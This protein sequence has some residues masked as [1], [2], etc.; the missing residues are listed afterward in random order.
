MQVGSI[1]KL[2]SIF[3]QSFRKLGVNVTPDRLE[4]LA[5]TVYTAMTV[6]TRYFHTLE[7]VFNLS[8]PQNAIVSFTAIY[9]DIVYFQV[10][11][12]FSPHIW[13]LLSPFIRWN[14]DK[15]S[16]VD[17]IPESERMIHM[18]LDLFD[19]RPGQDI[20][21]D[22]IMNEFL[23]ALVM[24]KQLETLLSWK[25]L[26]LI[27]VCIEG[28]IPFRAVAP[29]EKSYFDQMEL[30]FQEVIKRYGLD[31]S[32]QELI[33][34]LELAVSF[35][36]RDI[37]N[38]AEA[39]PGRFLENTWKLL[40]ETNVALRSPGV[41]TVGA[42]REALQKMDHFFETLNVDTV[43]K[44]YR[45]FPS[46]E[47]YDLLM[48][49]ARYNLQVARKYMS[50]KIL[51][52]TILE[53]L[54]LATGGDAPLALFLGDSPSEGVNTKRLENYLPELKNPDWVDSGSILYELLESGRATR[55]SFEMR[56]SPLSLFVYKSIPP[57]HLPVC[58][59]RM[60]DFHSGKLSPDDFLKGLSP[61]VI[62]PVARACSFMVP[63]RQQSLLKYAGHV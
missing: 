28:T 31:L 23:S 11:N 36:N 29:G 53:A 39:D 46:A 3:Q 47:D 1:E 49:Q 55:S 7:H 41:Y 44:Q 13:H 37:E 34:G 35:A 4:T 10:D 50:I 33:N 16:V 60:A 5:V 38:F 27:T 59:Q 43:F 58:V 62:Q 30:R 52:S 45:G 18:A 54:A 57:E 2:I 6:P 15:L 20:A 61:S 51:G 42:Y 12:G 25:D 48:R 56:N 19:V 9:H 21:T 32:Q 40:P 22:G 26:A 8:D 14:N 24:I 17:T 63:T